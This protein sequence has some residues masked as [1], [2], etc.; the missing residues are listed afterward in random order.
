MPPG[1]QVNV[2]VIAYVY[3]HRLARSFREIAQADARRSAMATVRDPMLTDQSSE[4]IA[5]VSGACRR[6]SQRELYFGFVGEHIGDV[7]KQPVD[8]CGTVDKRTERA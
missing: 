1:R 2:I 3:C 8:Q 7:D 6:I 5:R 4:V